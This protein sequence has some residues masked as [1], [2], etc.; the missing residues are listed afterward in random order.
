[1]VIIGFVITFD[2]T[3]FIALQ[4]NWDSLDYFANTENS[5]QII[6]NSLLNANT[7]Y[8]SNFLIFEHLI[9]KIFILHLNIMGLLF[10]DTAN[11]FKVNNQI[12]YKEDQLLKVKFDIF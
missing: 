3:Y 8:D 1:M 10:Q 7:Q 11:L 9:N 5:F 12:I 4:Q 6:I 2:Q